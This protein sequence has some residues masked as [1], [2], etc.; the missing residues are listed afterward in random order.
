MRLG[1][2][3]PEGPYST[4]GDALMA[5]ANAVYHFG[6]RKVQPFVKAGAGVVRSDYTTHWVSDWFD[7]QGNHFIEPSSE[8]VRASK[9]GIDLGAGIKASLS[10]NLS[11]RV[12]G[13]IADTTPGEG[14]N[15]V[16]LI[17]NAG[18]GFHW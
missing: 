17:L 14:Y 12:E 4:E 8:H 1:V 10:R 18:L 2:G 13:L 11:F 3:T 7:D 16:T 15:W 5:M 9:F 6:G